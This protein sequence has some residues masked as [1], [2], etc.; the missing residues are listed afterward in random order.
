VSGP[1]KIRVV[2]GAPF[3]KESASH[4]GFNNFTP[5]FLRIFDGCIEVPHE[6]L[7]L[8][9]P[10]VEE[11]VRV[12]GNADVLVCSTVAPEAL[13]AATHLKLIHSTGA[14]VDSLLKAAGDPIRERRI[15]VANVGGYMAIGVAEHA[16]AL[17]LASA[18]DIVNRSVS[19]REGEWDTHNSVL[20]AGK[21]MGIVGLGR[22]GVEV[23]KRGR[24]FGMSVIAIKRDPESELEEGLEVDFLGGFRDLERILRSSDFLVLC[25]PLTT[26]TRGM[27]GEKELRSMKPTAYLINIG[28]GALVDDAALFRALT[29][30]WI[31]GAGLDVWPSPMKDRN[32]SPSGVNKL[33]SVV[34]TPHIAG[35]TDQ[36]V[37]E[38]AQTIAG[39]I[40]R[41]YEGRTPVN[42]V[43]PSLGY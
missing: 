35:I 14:G 31:A 11:Q 9:N 12:I 43:D 41:V 10:S 29:E 20:L 16:M 2:L 1:E 18:K 23:A 17:L 38:S 33:R 25:A 30:G 22:I 36:I 28:R 15:P 21:T 3:D 8:E 5:E 4:G 37:R 13:Q 39:N 19:M 6:V 27:I 7:R 32:P 42:L 26:E 40:K 24:A 34:A